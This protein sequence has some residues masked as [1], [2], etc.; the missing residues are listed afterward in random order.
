MRALFVIFLI[1]ILAACSSRRTAEDAYKEG[2]YLESIELIA[3]DM[4]EKGQAKLD[5]DDLARF[6][7]MVSNV[8]AFYEN[9][10]LS[11]DRTD[12]ATRITSYESLLQM[13]TRLSDRFYSQQVYFFNNK[14]DIKQLRQ[15]I[16]EEY[17]LYGN[18]I[19]AT[20]GQ[21]YYRKATL[22]R[23]GMEQYKYKDIE[24]LYKKTN[25]KY[26]QVAAQ[27]NYQQG[28]ALAEIKSYKEA[29]EHFTN[30][31]DIYEPLGKYK[32]S[33]ELATVYDK[34]YRLIEA[35]NFY[36]QASDMKKYANTYYEYREIANLYDNAAKIYR[37]YGEYKES[38]KLARQYQEKGIIKIYCP[39]GSYFKLIEKSISE[40]YIRLVTNQSIAN[41]TIKIT[42]KNRYK[43]LNEKPIMQA[44]SE[45]IVVK[46]VQQTNADGSVESKDIYKTYYFNLQTSVQANMLELSTS[47][48]V[49]GDYLYN[50]T[51][52]ITKR[53]SITKYVYSGDVPSKYKNRTSGR[54]SSEQALL[55][56]AKDEQSQFIKDELSELMSV[57][58]RL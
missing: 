34:K 41:I 38:S 9:Q 28:K 32:D 5:A 46:T 35:Q 54:Y 22:Y 40:N 15:L 48:N 53:S 27:E 25:T 36:Q 39:P 33:R 45:N 26:M 19:N 58:E 7:Q 47:F 23:K 2:K 18:S 16:A 55:D 44:M 50:K 21:S 30:A 37:P 3:L 51:D 10:L 14:Y 1:F 43:N 13:K 31:A 8:M 12:Y 57:L 52:T 6:S 11:A 24:V 20:D 56:S 4:E 49:S 42:D 29:S 17:Y